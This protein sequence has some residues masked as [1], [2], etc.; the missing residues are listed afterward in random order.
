[1]GGEV[2]RWMED[3]RCLVLRMSVSVL[4]ERRGELGLAL[5]SAVGG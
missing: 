3:G 1:V 2:V 4:V 5:F